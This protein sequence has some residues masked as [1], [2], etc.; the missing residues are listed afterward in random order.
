MHSD[1]SITPRLLKPSHRSLTKHVHLMSKLT[2]TCLCQKPVCRWEAKR[3][4]EIEICFPQVIFLMVLLFLSH[5]T[6]PSFTNVSIH[7]LLYLVLPTTGLT[8]C[9]PQ[10]LW[11]PQPTCTELEASTA[12]MNSTH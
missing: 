2:V 11:A 6:N 5:P 12:T 8:C 4:G 1:V 9:L 7:P 3:G 10:V